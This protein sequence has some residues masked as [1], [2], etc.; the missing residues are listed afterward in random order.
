M[1]PSEI[2]KEARKIDPHLF[3]G[4]SR[5]T[6]HGWIDRSGDSPRWNDNVL[7][8]IEQGKGN[9]PG[10]QNGGRP[11]ILVSNKVVPLLR[12]SP[13]DTGSPS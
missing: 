8:R 12:C 5:S 13:K 6:V 4:L 10:H 9:E 2:V 7:R 11:G 1:S 3:A